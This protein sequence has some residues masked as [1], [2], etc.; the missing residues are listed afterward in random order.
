M[1]KSGEDMWFVLKLG[2]IRLTDMIVT[3]A[4]EIKYVLIIF[5]ITMTSTF[6]HLVS[7]GAEWTHP[8]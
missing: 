2:N 8:H 5:T 3:S 4:N 1:R 6:M 7:A